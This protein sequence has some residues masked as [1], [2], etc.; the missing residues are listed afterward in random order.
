MARPADGAYTL[1]VRATDTL[2]NTTSSSGLTTASFTID[3][4]APAAPVISVEESTS[5]DD[6]VRVHRYELA[7]RHLL[8]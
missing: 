5:T 6:R 2:G 3:T 7:E 1:Y 8:V 4:V